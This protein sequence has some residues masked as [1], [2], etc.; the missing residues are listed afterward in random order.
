MTVRSILPGLIISS[1]L[2]ISIYASRQILVG[3]QSFS[4]DRLYAHLAEKDLDLSLAGGWKTEQRQRAARLLK[5]FY[6]D[7]GFPLAE[8]RLQIRE[9]DFVFEILEGP[10][11]RLG[12]VEFTGNQALSSEQL[13]E[14]SKFNDYLDFDHLEKSLEEIRSAYRNAGYVRATVEAPRIDVLEVRSDDHFPVPFR[15]RIENRIRLTIPV[16][17]GPQYSYGK[18]SLPP[19]LINLQLSPPGAGV[20][21][22][23]SELLSF[24]DRVVQHF[25][26]QGRLLKDFRIYQRIDDIL[27]QVHLDVQYELLPPLTIR[28]IDFV[29]NSRYPDS[30]YRR[31]LKVPEG[32]ELD[33]QTL[34]TSLRELKRT[35][36]L[37]SVSKDDIELIIDYT[38]WKPI[39]SFT[40]MR[41]NPG[42]FFIPSERMDSAG[43]K[44]PYSTPSQTC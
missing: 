13:R 34:E 4:N 22:N 25:K 19:D 10:K 43:W 17:E 16:E 31:E 7:R 37:A 29:G 2:S 26:E 28:R 39:S 44:Q 21:Y 15:E 6:R 27:E 24:R 12:W 36:V 9:K 38:H 30:F 14:L 11:A 20:V 32:K 1:L 18:I 40:S 5:Q 33:P 41:R 8:V 3:N 42:K 35:G 23:E